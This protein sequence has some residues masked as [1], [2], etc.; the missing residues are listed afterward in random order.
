MALTELRVDYDG[1][2]PA[3]WFLRAQVLTRHHAW[4][5]VF[6]MLRRTRHGWH[7][8]I[9]VDAELDPVTVVAAQAILGSDWKREVFVLYR[10]A[11]LGSYA[12]HW[13]LAKRWNALYSSKHSG[14]LI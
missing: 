8:L 3:D 4:P 11:R 6:T 10:A 1:R 2:L 14:I 13:R 12:P 7:L 5:V 9:A